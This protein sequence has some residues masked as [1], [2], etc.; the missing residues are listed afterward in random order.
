MEFEFDLTKSEANKAKH[1]LD[2]VQAQE[3]WTVFGVT[4]PLPFRGEDRW[5]RVGKLQSR[6]WLA[7][8][9]KRSGRIRLIS[10]RRARKGEVKLHDDAERREHDHQS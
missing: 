2:F 10:V 7:V 5:L 1:G 9:A 3:L 4:G 6:H 8:F